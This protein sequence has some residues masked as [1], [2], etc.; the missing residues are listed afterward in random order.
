ML[1]QWTLYKRTQ[2]DTL[3]G[4]QMVGQIIAGFSGLANEWWRW[5]PQE[6]INEMLSTEDAD[7]HLQQRAFHFW[8]LVGAI[9]TTH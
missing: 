1:G 7:Q 2:N 4:Q 8:L 6:A 3:T 5:I 9:S